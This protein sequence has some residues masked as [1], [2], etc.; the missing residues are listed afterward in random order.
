MI[1]DRGYIIV[2]PKEKFKNWIKLNQE[3]DFVSLDETEPS[4]Y[5]IEDNFLEDDI[6]IKSYYEE[7]FM[8]ELESTGIHDSFWPEITLDEFYCLFELKLGVSV[9]DLKS[10]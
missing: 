6:V 10:K 1:L 2:E 7:I 5:L 3:N 8:Y 4:I 9:I